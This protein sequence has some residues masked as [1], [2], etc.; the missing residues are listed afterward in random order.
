MLFAYIQ[1][2]ISCP[3]RFIIKE[4]VTFTHSPCLLRRSVKHSNRHCAQADY[5]RVRILTFLHTYIQKYI[6]TNYS[7]I[8]IAQVQ[9]SSFSIYP[10]STALFKLE[11]SAP[12]KLEPATH[13]YIAYVAYVQITTG[14]ILSAY[15]NHCL[16]INAYHVSFIMLG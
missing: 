13:R 3:L 1:Q 7:F 6:N 16:S 12:P 8:Q 15:L 2:P 5:R 4:V 14:L 9:K 11:I 10:L